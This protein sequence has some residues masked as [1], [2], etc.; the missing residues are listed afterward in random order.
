MRV[1][2]AC[3]NM[4]SCKDNKNVIKKRKILI[5]IDNNNIKRYYDKVK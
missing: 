4:T 1:R 2:I 5:Y 3:I